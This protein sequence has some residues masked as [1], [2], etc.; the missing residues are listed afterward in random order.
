MPLYTDLPVVLRAPASC[1]AGSPEASAQAT[2]GN[3]S[4]VPSTWWGRQG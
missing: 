3:R 4:N 2:E 1:L